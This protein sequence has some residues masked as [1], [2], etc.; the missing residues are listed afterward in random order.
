MDLHPLVTDWYNRVR[1]QWALTTAW[2]SKGELAA[3][4]IEA[5]HFVQVAMTLPER[6]FRGLAFEA[7]ARL[8]LAEG[9]LPKA[10]DCIAR[11]MKEME[12]FETPLT[13][14]RVH[15]TAFELYRH[16]GEPDVAEA[17]RELSRA[18]IMMLANSLSADEPLRKTFLSAPVVQE[19]L[20]IGAFSLASS[21][22]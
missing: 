11:A 1:L 6:T 20:R 17:H 4:R 8:A 14:W 16:M 21:S 13:A 7:N 12:G 5:E 2:L 19:I 10:K 18:T 15:A 22:T 3:A 9:E